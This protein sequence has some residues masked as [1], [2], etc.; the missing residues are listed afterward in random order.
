[1]PPEQ[2]HRNLDKIERVDV[3]LC[4]KWGVMTTIS[5]MSE[6][7]R[8]FLY[9]L[10]WCVIVVGDLEKPDVSTTVVNFSNIL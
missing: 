4:D 3:K 5:A 8:R 7:V 1:M 10:D 2:L 6:S 9:K